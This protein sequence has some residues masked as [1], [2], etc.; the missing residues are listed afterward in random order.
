[1]VIVLSRNEEILLR[2]RFGAMLPHPCTIIVL[3]DLDIPQIMGVCGVH[4]KNSAFLAGALFSLEWLVRQCQEFAH[5]ELG[6]RWSAEFALSVA[7]NFY[8]FYKHTKNQSAVYSVNWLATDY[9]DALKRLWIHLYGAIE[10]LG[11]RQEAVVYEDIVTLS[12]EQKIC[13]AI[14]QPFSDMVGDFL[15]RLDIKN[16]RFLVYEGVPSALAFFQCNALLGEASVT[17][18]GDNLDGAVQVYAAP[19]WFHEEQVVVE[20]LQSE[21]QRVLVT[22]TDTMALRSFMQT[23]STRGISFWNGLGDFFW[24]TDD[25]QWIIACGQF[26]DEAVEPCIVVRLMRFLS[27]DKWEE[28]ANKLMRTRNVDIDLLLA[29]TSESD[30]GNALGILWETKCEYDARVLTPKAALQRCVML[31]GFGGEHTQEVWTRWQEGWFLERGSILSLLKKTLKS[32]KVEALR[33]EASVWCVHMSDVRLY[34]A[35]K[36]YVVGFSNLVSKG[37]LECLDVQ[38]QLPLLKGWLSGA[39]RVWDLCGVL[40]KKEVFITWPTQKDGRALGP[41]SLLELVKT[42]RVVQTYEHTFNQVTRQFMKVQPLVKNGCAVSRQTLSASEVVLL[43]DNPF[44]FYIRVVLGL[45]D[46]AFFGE[47]EPYKDFGIFVH[48]IMQ[49]TSWS[50]LKKLRYARAVF[51]ANNYGSS[52][53][54][55]RVTETLWALDCA[56]RGQENVTTEVPYVWKN[57]AG[58]LTIKMRLDRVVHDGGMVWVG[59]IKTGSKASVRRLTQD[60]PSGWQMMIAANAVVSESVSEVKMSLWWVSL[61]QVDAVNVTMTKEQVCHWGRHIWEVVEGVKTKRQNYESQ[62]S[63]SVFK[64]WWQ[65]EYAQLV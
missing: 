38:D 26:L 61:G 39:P 36:V 47:G 11:E 12:Q 64:I 52:W 28:Y 50:F 25:G 10:N 22:S 46:I 54:W 31:R 55:E 17:E 33:H 2:K 16:T 41:H 13:V 62:N 32:T 6:E 42:Q 56:F 48:D 9:H 18:A 59:D 44:D 1:M 51:V 14:N 30:L 27:P 53:T 24:D 63:S 34:N 45:K 20:A 3:T 40:G 60:I 23:L 8:T 19:S 43:L 35:D 7:E 37:L 21:R 49:H 57:D 15:T 58:D 4:S 65:C 29:E 5:N